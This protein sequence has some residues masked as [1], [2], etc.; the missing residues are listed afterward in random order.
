MTPPRP[1]AR[2]HFGETLRA[3]KY[4]HRLKRAEYAL[5]SKTNSTWIPRDVYGEEHWAAVAWMH[6]DEEHRIY[7]DE[8]CRLQR[9]A[10]L[11]NFDLNME[12]FRQLSGSA[13]LEAVDALLARHKNLRAVEDLAAWDGVEGVYVMVLDR[14]K[15]VYIGQASDIRGRIKK[16]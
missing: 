9:E 7:S 16:H 3:S 1:P 5:P 4:S 11:E 6:E 2:K 15:Q 10:A 13:Y 12:F 14:Y 8:F